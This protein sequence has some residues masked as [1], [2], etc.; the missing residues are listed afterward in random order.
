MTDVE[1]FTEF[2]RSS[3]QRF[4]R[5]AYLLCGETE[6]ARDL[7]QATLLKMYRVWDRVRRTDHVHAY[8]HKT[9]VHT[10]LETQRR[11]RRERSLWALPDPPAPPE[12]SSDLRLTVLDALAELPPRARAV[13][14]LRYW[15]DY[16]V[17]QTAEALSCA[18]GTVKAHSSRALKQLRQRLGDTFHQLIEESS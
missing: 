1:D 17:D 9:L 7:V 8:A 11:S 10:F 18:H 14:V 6:Q 2:A 13:V 3:E 16:S 4:Y 5:H 12:A 15:E